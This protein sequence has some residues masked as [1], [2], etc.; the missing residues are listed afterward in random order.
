MAQ[1]E[2]PSGTASEFAASEMP[3]SELGEASPT[4]GGGGT[5][6]PYPPY[7]TEPAPASVADTIIAGRDIRLQHKSL[8]RQAVHPPP[9]PARPKGPKATDVK[10]T[11]RSMRAHA[12]CLRRHGAVLT[13]RLERMAKPPRRNI[14]CLWR[15]HAH[16]LPPET[17][18]RLRSML[19]A[20][21]PFKP[22]QAYEYFVNLRKTK[23]KTTTT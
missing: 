16:Q 15:E 10:L 19:D 7:A 22:D 23:K 2:A 13:D 9:K 17:I 20:D 18:A 14:I 4:P 1:S 5:F 12:R 21:E 6:P 3:V 8:P 11:R